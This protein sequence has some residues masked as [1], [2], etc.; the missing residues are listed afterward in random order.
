MHEEWF[1][2]WF[3]SPYYP[4]L[5]AHRDNKEADLFVQNI[6]AVLNL[7]A[8]ARVLDLACGQGRHSRALAA[9]GYSVTGADLSRS[10]IEKAKPFE[11]EQL[12]FVLHDMRRPVAIN[13]FD[14]VL[15]L[16]TSFGYF[17]SVRDNV[18]T[19]DAVHACLR[20][21]GLFL[22][23][24]F[25]A[26]QVKQMVSANHSGIVDV[27]GIHFVW[28]KTIEEDKVIKKIKVNDNGTEHFFRESVALFS[29]SDFHAML[30]GK[31][32]ILKTFG[33]YHLS[34]F[35]AAT[36]PRLILTCRKK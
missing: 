29:L 1:K 31:F 3:D 24:Y 16:F 27:Q 34:P 36:S 22:I 26:E 13:Y 28:E 5:Y 2:T 14:A 35:D 8:S 10:S 18:R 21:K 19:I 7:H 6:N 32:E 4:L 15:N 25:N 20:D 12:S 33:D 30:E 9:L 23:D 17:E 11:T